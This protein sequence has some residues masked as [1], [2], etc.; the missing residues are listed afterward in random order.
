VG[1]AAANCPLTALDTDNYHEVALLQAQVGIHEI[2]E[3]VS[4][5]ANLSSASDSATAAKGML[6]LATN[7]DTR[8]LVETGVPE[9]SALTEIILA[10]I[11]C[12]VVALAPFIL[13]YVNGETL[14]WRAKVS[15]FLSTCWVIY[16]II[17]CKCV[18]FSSSHFKDNRTLSLGESVY[19]MSQIITTVGYGDISPANTPGQGLV[20]IL[21]LWA[22]LIVA[23][24]VSQAASIMANK[25]E[26]AEAHETKDPVSEQKTHLLAALFGHVIFGGIWVVVLSSAY[27]WTL[28]A[29]LFSSIV[30]FTTV[31]L[32]VYTPDH[33]EGQ[34]FVAY[35]ML[36][37][38]ASMA[39]VVSAFGGLMTAL[40]ESKSSEKAQ[41]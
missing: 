3:A 22:I 28:E 35:W 14:S 36:I 9:V 33:K 34:I 5:G 4:R 13:A 16:G 38:T 21:V 32:G 17:T 41:K 26:A 11:W 10:L 12:L 25:L 15:S 23:D 6:V 1:L 29:S 19:F 24:S 20:A 27:G 18:L 40:T 7:K 30:T 8:A 31:G 39:N 37:G 2:H